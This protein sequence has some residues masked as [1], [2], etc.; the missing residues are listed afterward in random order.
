MLLQ[1]FFNSCLFFNILSGCGNVVL[2][3]LRGRR[4]G[5]NGS[6]LRRGFGGQL[7]V[8]NGFVWRIVVELWAELLEAFEFFDG[9]AVVAFGLGL[10][11]EEEG[12]GAFAFADHLM[13]A[14]GEGVGAVLGLDVFGVDVEILVEGHVGDF[15]VVVAD[16]SVEGEVEEPGFETREPEDVVLGEG[17]AFD[18]EEFLGVLGRVGGDQV[19]AEAVDGVAFFDFDDGEV[20]AGEGV[21]AGVPGGSGLAFGGAGAGGF[22]GVGAVGGELFVGGRFGC[23]AMGLTRGPSSRRGVGAGSGGEKGEFAAAR[24]GNLSPLVFGPSG[25]EIGRAHV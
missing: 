21:L 24:P 6:R 14:G 1:F 15:V 7:R 23:H 18:G 19:V 12:P 8:G 11:A 4:R 25:V 2:C 5:R 20:R 17:D 10:V 16:R 13:E 22:E 3:S 9:A